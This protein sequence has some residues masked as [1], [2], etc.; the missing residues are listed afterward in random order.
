MAFNFYSG[1]LST[2]TGGVVINNSGQVSGNVTLGGSVLVTGSTFNNNSTGVWK[3][4]GSNWFYGSTNAINN[5]GLIQATGT[6]IFNSPVGS[7]LTF[8]NS[9]LVTVGSVAGLLLG[10]DGPAY[11]LSAAMSPAPTEISSSAI[12]PGWNSAGRSRRGRATARR[13]PSETAMAC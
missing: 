10:L 7:T 5:S 2:N 4:N 13:F 6:T 3:V 8:N 1:T 11:T 9:L 12:G